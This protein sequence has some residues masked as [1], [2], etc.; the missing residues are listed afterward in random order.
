LAAS[1]AGTAFARTVPAIPLQSLPLRPG[2]RVGG[3]A[4]PDAAEAAATTGALSSFVIES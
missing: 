2:S 3:R 4:I 1:L